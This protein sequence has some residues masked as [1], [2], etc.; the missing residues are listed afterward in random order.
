MAQLGDELGFD[1]GPAMANRMMLAPLTNFQSHEDGTLSDDEYHWLVARAKGGF[2]LTMTC[3][4]HV[5]TSGKAFSGQLGIWS[6]DHIAGLTRLADGIREHGSTSSVQLHHGG[7]RAL[8]ELTG[9][10]L[11]APWNGGE[12]DARALTT[13]EVEAVVDAFVAGAVRAEKAGFDG[14]EIH[15]AHGY[16]LCEFLNVEQNRREDGY[17]GDYAGRTRIFREVIAGIRAS[18]GSDFQLGL[19]LSPERFGIDTAEA[20]RLAEEL[21]TGGALDYLDMSLWDCFKEP[22]D[23]GF[24]GKSLIDWFTE[25]PRA[26]CRLGVAGKLTTAEKAQA[27]IDNGADFVLIGRGAILHHNWPKLALADAGFAATPLPVTRAYLASEYLGPA[28]VNYMATGWPNFVSD[29]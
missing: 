5:Q 18:T 28:F 1:H 21:M 17:G 10:Q 14:V 3:A 15:G 9:E 24:K 27:A 8:T 7:E 12:F 4:A 11:V 6:D 13:A 23:Q 16:L 22:I 26:N 20:R 19:R 25:L 2:G 29:K